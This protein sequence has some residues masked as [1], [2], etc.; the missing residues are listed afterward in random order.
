M[1]TGIREARSSAVNRIPVNFFL[2]FLLLFR[3]FRPVAVGSCPGSLTLV[4]TAPEGLPTHRESG[5]RVGLMRVLSS[6]AHRRG[7]SQVFPF[8]YG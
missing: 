3:Q 6:P 8:F 1:Q 4:A 2:F 7:I 5:A